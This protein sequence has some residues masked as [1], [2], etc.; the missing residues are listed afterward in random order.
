MRVLPVS[1]AALLVPA[2]AQAQVDY[3]APDCSDII[4]KGC[5]ARLITFDFKQ[6][7]ARA[8]LEAQESAGTTLCIPPRFLELWNEAARRESEEHCELASHALD[9][10]GRYFACSLEGPGSPCPRPDIG[11]ALEGGGSKSAPFSL[12]VLAGLQRSGVLSHAG[13]IGSASG[14]TYA[15]YFYYARILDRVYDPVLAH[16][17]E[18]DW[19]VDCFPSMYGAVMPA[20]IANSGKLRWCKEERG[21]EYVAL[22]PG[23]PFHAQVP[24]QY[25]VKVGQDLLSPFQTLRLRGT[26]W[27]DV[28]WLA[29]GGLVGAFI[30]A[31]AISMPPH[32]ILHGLFD[33]P[34]NFA[35]TREAY[36]SGIERA[37]GHSYESWNRALRHDNVLD[38]VTEPDAF[39]TG[40]RYMRSWTLTDLAKQYRDSRENCP[41]GRKNCGFPLWILSTSSSP[42]RSANF[43][44][45]P[46]PRDMQRFSFE[47]GPH[48]H[49]SG[50]MGFLDAPPPNLS[51]RDA[52]GI[53]AAF[54]DDQQRSVMSSWW[55]QFF[56]SAGVFAVNL[57]W[58]NNIANFNVTPEKRS[59]Y[60][61][62]PWP[63]YWLPAFQGLRAPYVRLSDGGNI[64]NLGVAALLRRGVRN[65]VVSA[66]TD[67]LEGAFPSLCK[68][69]NE[70][71]LEIPQKRTQSVY[72]LHVPALEAFDQV[73]NA[74]L[75]R[76]EI[77]VWGEEGV[78]QLFCE[79]WNL[80][81]GSSW[82]DA[83]WDDRRNIAAP[84]GYDLWNW[85]YPIVEGCVVRRSPSGDDAT[86]SKSCIDAR[87]QGREISRLL[88]IKPAIWQGAIA[89]QVENDRIASCHW[90]NDDLTIG[91][92]PAGIPDG[93]NLPCVTLAYLHNNPADYPKCRKGG[94]TF[95]QDNFIKMT[96]NSSYTLFGAYYDL[97]RHV[98]GQISPCKGNSSLCVRHP[99]DNVIE[100]CY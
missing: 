6:H 98:A 45:A 68:L 51:L 69:K 20:G 42:G 59:F 15:A 88:L 83:A 54:L 33:T 77:A 31:Q 85:P 41:S 99:S 94:G 84:T 80:P 21:G 65:V 55:L 78:R 35:P 62:L 43:W 2:L 82:C 96:L 76:Q 90:G 95:P 71:E 36:R 39:K 86:H 58:G 19:F 60:Q 70:L 17:G 52:V 81:P 13:I 23:N 100:A 5:I 46:Q 29:A 92:A 18:R 53:S 28:D 89:R 11:V 57:E 7:A 97:G 72:K 8:R 30:A 16:G 27:Y 40:T 24:Y 37:Y 22:V 38:P 34:G 44:I 91:K 32:W 3:P 74:A 56:A 64:D 4:S 12:G 48:G 10:V 73:C 75:D 9:A 50:L 47:L 49:G 14:G 25:Q 93:M 61:V 1:L 26:N 67:D 79:R 63:I 66:S 87:A